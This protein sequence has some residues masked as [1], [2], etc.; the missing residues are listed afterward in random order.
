MFRVI[1]YDTP[2]DRRR[3]QIART[4]KNFGER[5]QFSVFECLLD[6]K[7]F[8]DLMANLSKIILAQEDSIRVYSFCSTCE[9]LVNI[10]GLGVVTKDRK[11]Y[12]L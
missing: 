7:E 10:L 11:Y 5:V 9:K 6:Q 4:L 12:I 1:S 8:E 2:D 3:N